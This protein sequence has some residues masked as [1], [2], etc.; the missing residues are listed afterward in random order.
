MD[1][2]LYFYREAKIVT[3]EESNKLKKIV[4]C[5]LVFSVS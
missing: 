5:I 4:A 3:A 2:D 1:G